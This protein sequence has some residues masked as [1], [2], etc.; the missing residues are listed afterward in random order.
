MPLF[1][2]FPTDQTFSSAEIIADD[3]AAVFQIV[4]GLACREADVIAD[5]A[6]AFSLRL[7]DNGL[8]TIFQRDREEEEELIPAFG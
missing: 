1:R 8:W 5:G 2:I 7:G 6:Y 4:G 3:P